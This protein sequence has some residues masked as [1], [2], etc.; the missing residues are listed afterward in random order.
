MANEWSRRLAGKPSFSS[1][2][3]GQHQAGQN[4][5]GNNRPAQPQG[6]EA[7]GSVVSR[8]FAMRGYGRPQGDAE[9]RNLWTEIAG[10]QVAG[11]TRV[12]GLKNGVL[13]VGVSSSPLLSELSAFHH[14]RLLEALQAKHGTKIRDLKFKRMTTR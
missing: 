14:E 9:L 3:T 10:D 8:L 12:M 5:Q 7:I 4:R 1:N 2:R 11:G 13:T 6:P